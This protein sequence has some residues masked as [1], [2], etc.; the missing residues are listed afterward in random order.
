[1]GRVDA[2]EALCEVIVK[3]LIIPKV[4]RARVAENEIQNGIQLSII[5]SVVAA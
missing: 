1:M 2:I 5:N 3:T 4:T